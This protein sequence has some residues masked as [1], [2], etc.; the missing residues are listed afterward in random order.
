M[1]QSRTT[2]HYR[3]SQRKMVPSGPR[4]HTI[5][6][7]Y[8]RLTPDMFGISR[9]VFNWAL[10]NAKRTDIGHEREYTSGM[11]PFEPF[12]RDYLDDMARENVRMWVEVYR[13]AHASS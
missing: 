12:T 13:K 11:N 8:A 2:R 7:A 3:P 9:T 1:T 4:P 6:A 10:A 5:G